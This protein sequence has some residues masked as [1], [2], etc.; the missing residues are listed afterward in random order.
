MRICRLAVFGF[1]GGTFRIGNDLPPFSMRTCRRAA[2]TAACNLS[3]EDSSRGQNT[4]CDS[5]QHEAGVTPEAR[6]DRAALSRNGGVAPAPASPRVL[7]AS[8]SCALSR[9]SGSFL[10]YLRLRLGDAHGEI[11]GERFLARTFP[12]SF[13]PTVRMPLEKSYLAVHRGENKHH[14]LWSS[15]RFVLLP[16]LM[17]VHLLGS[18][19]LLEIRDLPAIELGFS[20]LESD[21]I[22]LR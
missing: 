10:F 11:S 13:H 2:C 12:G 20:F 22:R 7:A 5:R 14:R 18:P 6:G 8:D 9:P 1:F 19:S 15:Q 21:Q 16:D 3:D 4:C 17:E